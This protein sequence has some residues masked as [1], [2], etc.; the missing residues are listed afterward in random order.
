[1]HSVQGLI[2][3]RVAL[4]LVSLMLVLMVPVSGEEE[5]FVMAQSI[6]DGKLKVTAS[7]NPNSSFEFVQ[8]GPTWELD[9]STLPDGKHTIGL[10]SDGEEQL[11]VFWTGAQSEFIWEDALIQMVMIDRFVNGNTSNDGLTSGSSFE[12]DWQGGDL[13]GV[14]QMI[15]SG[16]FENLG[17]NAIWLSP[18]NTNPNGSFIAMDGVH[19]V[20]GYHGYW[21]VEPRQVNP[22]FGG[23]VAL[24]ELVRVAH[25]RGMRVIADFTIN[26]VH[27]DHVYFKEHPEWFNDGCLCGTSGC[28]WTE[29]RLDCLFMSYM[30]DIDWS[31]EE[32]RDQMVSDALWWIERFDLD[33]LRID[34]VKH[35]DD[36]AITALSTAIH[37]RFERTGND[38][39][40]KGET[41]MGWSGHSL[42]DNQEQYATINQYISEDGLD[43]QADFVLYHAVV[44]NVFSKQHMDYRHLDYWTNRSQD[45]Y[46]QGAVMTPYIGSH[47]TPRII[48]RIENDG[49]QWNQWSDQETPGVPPDW[50]YARLK[51]SLGWLLTTPGAPVIYMGDEFGMHGGADPDNRRM[52]N[53]SLTS[54]QQDLHDFTALLGQFRLENEALRRGVYSTYYADANILAYEMI[55]ESQELLVVLNRGGSTTLDVDYDEVLLGHADLTVGIL[56]IPASSISIIGYEDAS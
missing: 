32:A 6:Q 25:S 16:Y 56:S 52:L 40:L 8:N 22:R 35:V 45:Q 46:V 39:Y 24:D 23:E 19:R 54:E 10:S 12:A 36:S 31:N 9:L 3:V 51:Q 1:M 29:R 2:L 11:A 18:L 21:P 28:D 27:E 5:A 30:P 47:D 15:E 53:F 14:T 48:S 50:A 41:A 55:S 38:V 20:S 4:L 44:D 26:H 49:T 37:E 13:Q 7:E 34:A 33:G 42:E 17:I 43:G